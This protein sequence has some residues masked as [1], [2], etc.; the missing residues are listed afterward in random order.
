MASMVGEI[1]TDKFIGGT[2]IA[3]KYFELLEEEGLQPDKIGLFEP[4]K[5]SYTP[6]RAIEMWTKDERVRK[7]RMAGGMI[8]K[9]KAPNF[10]F[11]VS[12]NRGEI[13]P[14]LN[15]IAFYFTLKSFQKESEK[16]ERTFRK[17]FELFDGIYGYISHEVPENRQHVT[18][19]LETRMPGVFW[20]NY[21]GSIYVNFFGKDKLLNGPW[22]KTEQLNSGAIVTYLANEPNKD[23]LQSDELEMKAKHYL[24][25]DSFGDQEEQKKDIFKNQIK[26]VPKLEMPDLR[27]KVE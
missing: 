27:V 2:E 20:C 16:I 23:I 15:N 12:W 24:G 1:Y 8:G 13:Y 10:Q 9:K 6:Q 11:D 17:T 22:F 18:G 3:K 14:R 21:F 7:N 19:T 5:E 4:L 26:R 25:I